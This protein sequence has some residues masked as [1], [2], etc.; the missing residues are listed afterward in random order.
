MI[1]LLVGVCVVTAIVSRLPLQEIVKILVVLISLPILLYL[2]TKL[3]QNPSQWT[4]DS[5]TLHVRFSDK[6]EES[7]LLS[8]IK[9]LR[10][11]PRSGGNLL[12]FFMQQ[13]K[14]T[15]RF[16]RNKLF[17]ADDDLNALI[18]ALKQQNVEYYYM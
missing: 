8:E 11:V 15:K 18:H 2:S 5:E 6:K 12:M 4:V 14:G 17:Q 7:I 3:S 13:G 9:Y 10:N 16:W 1:F